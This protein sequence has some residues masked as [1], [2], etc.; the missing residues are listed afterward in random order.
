MQAKCLF[1]ENAGEKK[2]SETEDFF[3]SFDP[4]Y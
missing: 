2:S 4:A 3:I 1:Y